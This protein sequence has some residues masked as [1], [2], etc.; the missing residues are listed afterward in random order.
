MFCFRS[1]PPPNL[2]GGQA[3]KLAFN[4]YCDR[5]LRRDV[6][7]PTTQPS[8]KLVTDKSETEL[9]YVCVHVCVLQ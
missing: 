6:K 7:P 3:H 5:D 2:P 8:A 9:K 1:P 4:Y